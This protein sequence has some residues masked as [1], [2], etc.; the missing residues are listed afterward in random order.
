[1]DSWWVPTQCKWIQCTRSFVCVEINSMLRVLCLCQNQLNSYSL[2]AMVQLIHPCFIVLR[3][4][5]NLK[6]PMTWLHVKPLPCL[7]RKDT[8]FLQVQMVTTDNQ[9]PGCQIY[10]SKRLRISMMCIHSVLCATLCCDAM[11]LLQTWSKKSIWVQFCQ[12]NF[13]CL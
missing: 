1:M 13:Q 11:F 8:F 12:P 3:T 5:T 7:T 6:E 2:Q 9:L 4:K 10:V